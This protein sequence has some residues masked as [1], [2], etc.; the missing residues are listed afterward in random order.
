MSHRTKS[1]WVVRAL[2]TLLVT[3]ALAFVGVSSPASAATAWN[4]APPVPRDIC[5]TSQDAFLVPYT[6]DTAYT[7]NGNYISSETW[8][9][10][11]GAATVTLVA[12]YMVISDPQPADMTFTMTFDVRSD[13]TC[14]DG[15]DTVITR[16]VACD[17]QTTG[18]LVEFTYVNTDD[19]A[20]RARTRPVGAPRC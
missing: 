15:V 2:T 7:W 4:P 9:P 12:S 8:I 13:A 10:T 11:G 1:S 20:D 16:I 19:G 3:T 14:V 18:T 17:P 6:P 5:G